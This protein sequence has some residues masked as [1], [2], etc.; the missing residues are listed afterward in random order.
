VAPPY[1]TPSQ[2]GSQFKPGNPRSDRMAR[3][4]DPLASANRAPARPA[5]THA[6]AP[7]G[8]P[9]IVMLTL[10]GQPDLARDRLEGRR[11]RDTP[12]RRGLVM[13]HFE[14]TDFTHRFSPSKNFPVVWIIDVRSSDTHAQFRTLSSELFSRKNGQLG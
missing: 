11:T 12:G 2:R 8:K 4:S 9:V 3:C 10:D 1:A 6:T 5:L 14:N 13:F 7:R